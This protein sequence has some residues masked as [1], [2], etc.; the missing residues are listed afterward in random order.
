MLLLLLLGRSHLLAA[1][2]VAPLLNV[3]LLS[4]FLA[5]TFFTRVFLLQLEAS[6]FGTHL[7][8]LLAYL[9]ALSSLRLL[10]TPQPLTLALVG[11]QFSTDV[12]QLFLKRQHLVITRATATATTTAS[13]TTVAAATSTATIRLVTKHLG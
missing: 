10:L 5:T 12:G 1:M 6:M 3:F 8:Y 7:A 11:G 9:L 13:S 4:L 2:L